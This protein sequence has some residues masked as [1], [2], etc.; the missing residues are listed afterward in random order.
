M[1][2]VAI[3]QSKD[4]EKAVREAISLIGGLDRVIYKGDKVLVKPEPKKRKYF[5]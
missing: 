5:W 3:T 4:I 1:S 2:T